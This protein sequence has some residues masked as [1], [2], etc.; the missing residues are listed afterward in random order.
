VNKVEIRNRILNIRKKKSFNAFN[1]KFKSVLKILKKEKIK[2]KNLG[3][4]F[5]YNYEVDGMHILKKFEKKK[6][7]ISLPKIK[8]NFQ[9]DFFSWST[10]DP[11]VINKYG[12]P[13]PIS[14]KI[15]YPDILL[16]PLVAYDKYLNRIGYGG[17]FYD[18]YIE[19]IKKNKKITTIGLAYSFQKV[20]KIPIDRYDK[21]LDFII[22]EI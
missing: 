6:Y 12:I 10:N 4:Y 7:I 5:P 17:G 15:K 9:M 21:K 1:I 19:K 2:G 13:E 20:K 18:R 16:I 11:L 22:T 3:G 8:N 14:D